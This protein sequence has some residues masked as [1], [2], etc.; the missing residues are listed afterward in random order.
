MFTCASVNLAAFKGEAF[1]EWQLNVLLCSSKQQTVWSIVKWWQLRLFNITVPPKNLFLSVSGRNN[2]NL[3]THFFITIAGGEF[4]PKGNRLGQKSVLQQLPV[5]FNTVTA[6][7][8]SVWTVGVKDCK[9]SQRWGGLGCQVGLAAHETT[10]HLPGP[11]QSKLNRWYK[12]AFR[13]V[14]KRFHFFR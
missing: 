2:T 10:S 11:C 13:Q 6:V 3:T 9:E 1:S 4:S 12:K 14:F 7:R 8:Q 5:G